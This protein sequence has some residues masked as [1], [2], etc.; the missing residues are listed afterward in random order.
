MKNNSF[1]TTQYSIRT[2]QN[3]NYDWQSLQAETLDRI[4]LGTDFL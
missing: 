3:Q 2:N 4:M 1:S